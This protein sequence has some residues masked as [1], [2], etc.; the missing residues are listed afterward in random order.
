MYY[1]TPAVCSFSSIWSYRIIR[2][3]LEVGVG[4]YIGPF[5]HVDEKRG[6]GKRGRESDKVSGRV[7][8][9]VR[10]NVTVTVGGD[11]IAGKTFCE[12]IKWHRVEWHETRMAKHQ[13]GKSDE[14]PA[15][16]AL[17]TTVTMN[18][19]LIP[20]A[21]QLNVQIKPPLNPFWIQVSTRP[22]WS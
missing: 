22:L 21:L 15:D 1:F 16:T 10:K 19:Q 13:T 3:L 20:T 6:E 11:K 2:H 9:R 14:L 5:D 18:S 12:E 4:Y 17:K 7:R 8:L